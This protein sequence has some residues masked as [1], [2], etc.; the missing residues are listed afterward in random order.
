MIM[1]AEPRRPESRQPEAR[2]H[3]VLHVGP[4]KTGSTSIQ[5]WLADNRNALLAA[6]I[7][8]PSSLG[9]NHSLLRRIVTRGEQPRAAKGLADLTAELDAMPRTVTQIVMSG[10]MLG[11][12]LRD[13][14]QISGVKRLFDRYAASYRIIMYLRRQD[15]QSVSLYSS[16]LH[17]GLKAELLGKPFPYDRA[18]T[19]WAKVFGRDQVVP[20]IFERESMVDGDAVADFIAASGFSHL[21]VPPPG[22]RTRNTSFQAAAQELLRLVGR[23]LE[24]EG[25]AIQGP[26]LLR[27]TPYWTMRLMLQQHFPGTGLLP[28]RAE[29]LEFYERCR[30]GNEQVRQQWFP[31]RATLFSEDFSRYPETATPLPSAEEVMQVAIAVIARLVRPASDEVP[32]QKR[33]KGK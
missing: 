5:A 2:R 28:S 18:L 14:Q 4:M 15:L 17:R 25:V 10:E 9:I 33:R 26:M 23:A 12:A 21:P 31:D 22:A 13:A 7:F 32:R 16:R 8:V 6:G 30:A 24:S 1:Q 27:N 19:A 11:Q 3:V 20:R 29:A